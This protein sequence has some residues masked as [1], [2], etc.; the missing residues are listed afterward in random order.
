M[1]VEGAR[2]EAPQ[3]HADERDHAVASEVDTIA[4]R[5]PATH[6]TPSSFLSIAA[7][8]RHDDEAT[9]RNKVVPRPKPKNGKTEKGTTAASCSRA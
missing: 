7:P 1:P 5:Q 9:A 2:E 8:G 6:D 3:H 4:E